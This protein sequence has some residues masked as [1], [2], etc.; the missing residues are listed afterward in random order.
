MSSK[1]RD[2]GLL[3]IKGL[4]ALNQADVILYDRLVSQEVLSL[5][6]RDAVQIAVG[7]SPGEDH[8]ASQQRIHDLLL[9][10]ARLGK[11]VVRLK[12]GDAF[13]FGRGGEELEFLSEHG[14]AYEVVPGI[15]AALA[16]AAYAG[17]PLTHRDHAHSVRLI[18]AHSS[19]HDGTYDW[20][21]VVRRKET[22]A[23]Y[24]G[25]SQL[26]WLSGQLMKHGCAG[27]TPFALIENGTRSNQRVLNG[28]LKDLATLASMHV[29]KAPCLLLV[30]ETVTLAKKLHWFGVSIN[31]RTAPYT[32]ITTT[33]NGLIKAA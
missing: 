26:A 11:Y 22:L 8:N 9:T 12:G 31:E 28:P 18:T 20:L 21:S 7:K 15:T 24:M 1:K 23:F 19:H 16:C 10:H 17:I 25:R 2:P 32:D 27:E 4:R 33:M 5:A 14:I 6:R 13:I 30:G 3:T 29:F